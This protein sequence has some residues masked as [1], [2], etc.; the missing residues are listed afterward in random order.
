MSY[1]AIWHSMRPRRRRRSP[2][3]PTPAAPPGVWPARVA[4]RQHPP[5][6]EA[7]QPGRVHDRHRP[8]G[9]PPCCSVLPSPCFPGLAQPSCCLFFPLPRPSCCLP[10]LAR[11][12]SCFAARA[13]RPPFPAAARLTTFPTPTPET[14]PGALPLAPPSRSAQPPSLPPPP[15][16]QKR[17]NVATLDYLAKGGDGFESLK[18]APSLLALGNR[19]DELMFDDCAESMPAPVGGAV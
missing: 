16:Q 14:R 15:K 11:A 2:H 4:P 13:W 5:G 1:A 12:F 6:R 10:C 19:I 9:E 7:P 3:P 8:Q 17:Y 18:G